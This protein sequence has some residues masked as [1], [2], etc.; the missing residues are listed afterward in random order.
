MHPETIGHSGNNFHRT[1]RPQIEFSY[2]RNV[3]A[4]TF[5]FEPAQHPKVSLPQKQNFH[6][7]LRNEESA[8]MIWANSNLL[9]LSQT[10][11]LSHKYG[12][13]F[14]QQNKDR[15]YQSPDQILLHSLC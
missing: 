3:A 1:T 4:H 14:Q 11:H 2:Y 5:L 10:S 9:V 13:C 7:L 6:D 8:K 15:F 12:L